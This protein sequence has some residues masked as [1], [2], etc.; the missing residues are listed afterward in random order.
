[1]TTLPQDPDLVDLRDASVLALVFDSHAASR[2]GIGVLMHRQPWVSRCLLA[3]DGDEARQLAVRHKPD[4]GIFDVTDAGPFVASY[5]AQLRAAH[6]AMP[7]VLTSRC[8][9]AS[10][11]QLPGVGAA[12]V[13]APGFTPEQ[14]VAAV[15]AALL[16]EAAPVAAATSVADA[17]QLSAREREVL[18]LI[19]TG[20][21]NREIAAALHVGTETVKKHAGGL[22]RKLRVR[23]RTE[24]AQRAAELLVA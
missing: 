2:I 4:V 6:P 10:V 22:Y 24:A 14:L 20:A 15:R 7:I 11:E 1:M 13:L 3:A 9:A 8:R 21:T 19:S 23:N 17:L 16:A 12:G 18:A 5:T